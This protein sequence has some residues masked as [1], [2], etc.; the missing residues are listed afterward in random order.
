MRL[1]SV[2]LQEGQL[3]VEAVESEGENDVI[4]PKIFIAA[5]IASVGAMAA[6]CIATGV[7]LVRTRE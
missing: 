2:T 3:E 6:L 4:C 5:L 1:E 7:F